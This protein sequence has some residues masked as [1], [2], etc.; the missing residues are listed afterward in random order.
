M[1]NFQ[2]LIRNIHQYIRCIWIPLIPIAGQQPCSGPQIQNPFRL[3][4]IGGDK[5]R[6][7][8]IEIVKAGN[9]A[10]AIPV[11]CFGNQ[12][13][14]SFDLHGLVLLNRFAADY[15][16]FD[17]HFQLSVGKI[18]PRFVFFLRKFVLLPLTIGGERGI[19]KP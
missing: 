11:I 6:C 4:D 19:L 16:I 17:C 7:A 8:L 12:V 15:S 5:I 3:T 2:H 14:L 18:A 10:S 9:E 13:E 1:G